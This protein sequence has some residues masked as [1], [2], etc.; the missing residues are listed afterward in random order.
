M[1]ET[2]L[3]VNGRWRYLYRVV[4]NACMIKRTK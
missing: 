4:H 3:K 1:D 2:H